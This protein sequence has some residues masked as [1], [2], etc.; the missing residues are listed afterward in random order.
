MSDLIEISNINPILKNNLLA[1]CTV[2]IKPWK[3]FFHEVTIFEKGQNRWVALPSRAYESNGERKYVE[4]VSFDNEGA[5]KRFRDQVCEAVDK[6]LAA[7][8][9]CKPEDLIK[10]DEPF[11]F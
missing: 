9:E 5:K 6:F 4:L 8:P 11:P 1:T 7:N 10:E 2:H 3:I